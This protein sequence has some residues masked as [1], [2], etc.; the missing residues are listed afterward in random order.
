MKSP[1]F[2]IGT[3]LGVVGF[4]ALSFLPSL[5][6]LLD[7]QSI[8]KIAIV[9]TKDIIYPYLPINA[10]PT[11]TPDPATGTLQ[12]APVSAGINFSKANTTDLNVLSDQVNRGALSAY[13][14]VEGDHPSNVTFRYQSKDR[15]GQALSAR[16][17]SILTSAAV[18]ARFKESGISPA[19]AQAL[20]ATPNL[21]IEPIVAGTLKDEKV[22][23][24]ST[25]LVYVLLILLY[26]TMLMYGIQVAMGVVEEK[27]S[28][29]ME[30]LI[31]AIRPIELMLGKVFGVGLL[32]LT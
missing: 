2:I 20:F 9:D 17:L 25:S 16:L 11:P 29:V 8:Q 14:I 19:Q 26:V 10:G 31:T 24:Q 23:A 21:K 32:G 1:G 4:L 13:V 5:F 22:V 18:E 6:K 30:I 12:G 27:S 28:R 3:I 7:S 15:P